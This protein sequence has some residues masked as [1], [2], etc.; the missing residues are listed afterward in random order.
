[1]RRRGATLVLIAQLATGLCIAG[2][3]PRV[4]SLS[5]PLAET[6]YAL[7]AQGQLI[8]VVDAAVFPEQLMAD[9]R[10]G[11]VP[12]IGSFIRPDLDQ[13]DR[14]HPDLILSDTLF[15]R[16][17]SETLR[18]KGYRVMHFE[19]T[20][21][22]DICTQIAMVGEAVGK[23]KEAQALVARMRAERN[24]LGA[25]AQALP[26]VKLYLEI[27]HEGPWTAGS[28]SPLNDLIA[29]AGGQNVF[30]DHAEGAFKTSDDEVVRRNPDII[31]SPIWLNAKV[32]GMDGIIP[33][34]QI[35]LRPGYDS[36]NAVKNSRVHYYD[37]ALFKHEGPRQILAIR[38]LAHLL[39][40]D[41]FPDPP[42]TIAWELGRIRQ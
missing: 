2:P 29:A 24:E 31:L 42:G 23:N 32:G 13:L 33:L 21:F 4:L 3:R 11:K 37:S 7:G 41:E 18:V 17:L 40:P 39:H 15:H 8:G 12:V 26:P 14:L 30:A 16:K 27:N 1:M 34:M 20:S 9:R 38:K 5:A 36:T 25:K 6:M 19:P 22:Q 28:K 35:F 10:A